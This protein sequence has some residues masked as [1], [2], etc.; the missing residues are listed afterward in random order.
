MRATEANGDEHTHREKSPSPMSDHPRALGFDSVLCRS[1]AASDHRAWSSESARQQGRCPR[2]QDQLPPKQA[3]FNKRISTNKQCDL[4]GDA[5]TVKRPN[6]VGRKGIVKRER[7]A[8]RRHGCPC[9]DTLK[10][11]SSSFDARVHG[12]SVSRIGG[13][14]CD[15]GERSGKPGGAGGKEV[16]LKGNMLHNTS[17]FLVNSCHIHTFERFNTFCR[18]FI[19]P[20]YL[21]THWKRWFS[22]RQFT[23][24]SAGLQ[25]LHLEAE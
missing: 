22:S 11:E 15:A 17:L 21:D 20:L 5:G 1:S 19:V 2:L 7:E 12:R 6:I 18:D 3:A 23:R 14:Y 25:T 9:K 10:G 16:R 13:R 24:S 8:L 4:M